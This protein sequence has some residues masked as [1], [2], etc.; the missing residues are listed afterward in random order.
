MVRRLGLG[1]NNHL[2]YT[3]LALNPRF[4]VY[5]AC[6]DLVCESALSDQDLCFPI[7]TKSLDTIEYIDVNLE[8]L[9]KRNIW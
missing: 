5:A 2:T 1:K 7:Y 8:E 4:G 6:K 9:L 3:S